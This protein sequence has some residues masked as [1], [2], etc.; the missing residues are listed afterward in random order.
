MPESERRLSRLKKL[1]NLPS[2]LL[3]S[4]RREQELT[5]W[6]EAQKELALLYP[7]KTTP[8]QEA[9][10]RDAYKHTC[11]GQHTDPETMP[12]EVFSVYYDLDLQP[13]RDSVGIVIGE[14]GRVVTEYYRKRRS[15]EVTE[16]L[17]SAQQKDFASL[18]SSSSSFRKKM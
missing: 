16:V 14:N 2:E 12:P 3:R 10:I 18:L 6:F 13:E 1:T 4:L 15:G 5:I 7:D 9:K 11:I 8:E 17:R